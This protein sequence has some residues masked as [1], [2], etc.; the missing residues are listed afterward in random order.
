[1]YVHIY[2]YVKKCK[3]NETYLHSRIA[4][5]ALANCILMRV[6]ILE[7][8]EEKSLQSRPSGVLASHLLWPANGRTLRC[9]LGEGGLNQIR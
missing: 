9:R 6:N 3:R 4:L 7:R 8:D 5:L 1:M 2:T